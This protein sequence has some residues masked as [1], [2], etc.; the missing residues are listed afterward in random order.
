MFSQI[1]PFLNDPI[2]IHSVWRI[3]QRNSN[4][5]Q[6]AANK[7]ASDYNATVEQLTSHDIT[8]KVSKFKFDLNGKQISRKYKPKER[9]KRGADGNEEGGKKRDLK[10]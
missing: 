8:N 3:I 4:K 9:R 5:S 1:R 10:S 7:N 2:R 6:A